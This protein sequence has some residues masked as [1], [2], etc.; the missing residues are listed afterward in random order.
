MIDNKEQLI[1][2]QV[3]HF[4]GL[5][6]LLLPRGEY[7]LFLCVLKRVILVFWS[8]F[9]KNDTILTSI[10]LAEGKFLKV[11]FVSCVMFAFI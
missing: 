10:R 11:C 1:I 4:Q 7:I 9:F 6:P 5:L 2:F 8:A 3:K